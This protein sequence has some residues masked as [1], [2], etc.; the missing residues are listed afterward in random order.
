MRDTNDLHTT[1]D[2][3]AVNRVG[4]TLSLELR[5][6]MAFPMPNQDEHLPDQIEAFVHQAGLEIQRRLA[7]ILI[8]KS[9][10]ELVLQQR[11]GKGGAGIQLRGTHP[12]T[13]KMTFGEVPVQRSRI[14]HKKDGTIDVGQPYCLLEQPYPGFSLRCHADNASVRV[15]FFNKPDL[16]QCPSLFQGDPAGGPMPVGL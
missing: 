13:F 14:L 12:F 6:E 9:D 7:Q 10:Q 15:S 5:L 1:I 8:E 4:Q 2:L 3:G 16:R 11:R